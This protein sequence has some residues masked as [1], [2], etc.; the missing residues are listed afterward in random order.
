MSYTITG[1]RVTWLSMAALLLLAPAAG[2]HQPGKNGA[3][4]GA[5]QAPEAA[6]SVGWSQLKTGMDPVEVLSLLEEP[7]HVK[8]TRVSTTWYYSDRKAEGP[9]VV[10]GTRLMRVERWRTP[11][12]R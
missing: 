7:R 9:H 11:A 4:V 2:C 6:W 3:D 5:G 8:V 1:V 10:F 12:S